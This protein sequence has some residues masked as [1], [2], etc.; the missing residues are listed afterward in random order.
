MCV[1]VTALTNHIS[2]VQAEGSEYFGQ[3]KKQSDR[4]WHAEIRRIETGELVRFAGIWKRKR[5]AI[6]EVEFI[7]RKP[8]YQG[9][10]YSP[11]IP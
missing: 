3:I 6:E 9:G 7:L 1:K 5:D 10:G 4:E 2:R 11:R 8:E